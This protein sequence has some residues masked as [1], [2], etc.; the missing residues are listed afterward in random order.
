MLSILFCVI[1]FLTDRVC[2]QNQYRV[3]S[4][5]ENFFVNGVTKLRTVYKAYQTKI[6]VCCPSFIQVE[7]ECIGKLVVKF[8]I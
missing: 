7:D 5:A 6:P 4:F 8:V 3:A 1:P 2:P